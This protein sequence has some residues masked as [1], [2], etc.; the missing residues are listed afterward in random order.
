METKAPARDAAGATAVITDFKVSFAVSFCVCH[1]IMLFGNCAKKMCGSPLLRLPAP[2]ISSKSV[3]D[4][5]RNWF[6]LLKL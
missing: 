1:A 2:R 5:V 3:G 4:R 6:C